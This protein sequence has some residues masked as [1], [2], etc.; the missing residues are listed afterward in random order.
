MFYGDSITQQGGYALFVEQYARNH[1]PDW[2]LHFYNAGVGGDTVQGG[3]AGDISLRL[4]RDVIRLKP[5]V[6]T[7]ML[8]MNDGRYR[9]MEPATRQAF[10]DG[11]RALIAR[12]RQA[13]PE[14]RLYLIRTSPFDDYSVTPDFAPGYDLALRELGDVVTAIGQENNIPVVDFGR[15]V[16]A[17]IQRVA[18]ENR[19][20]AAQLL[21]DRVHPGPA[22]QLVMGATLL[23]AW[24]APALVSRVAIDA[25]AGTV[26]SAENTQ[27]SAFASHD[28]QLSWEQLDRALP[29]PLNYYDGDTDLAQKAGADLE[30]L[31]QQRLIL[32]GLPA[33]RYELTIDD[34][35]FGPFTAAELAAG[36]NL[37]RYNTPM[38]WQAYQV[39][40]SAEGGH[41]RQRI[42]RRAPAVAADAL[43]AVEEA[44]QVLRSN[45]ARPQ[46]R[47]FSV[48]R[49]P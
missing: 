34:R 22:A 9:P 10:S 32:S 27:V 6:V 20:L 28:G 48:R 7:I 29:L 4:E 16:S 2:T 45:A 30:S 18:A 41:E 26:L 1:Y 46:V 38:R 25:T 5:T 47:K 24:Q 42:A 43:N 39:R 49:I 14:A 3:G 17:G 44:E 15:S 33:G 13:L 35:K 23:R 8:G 31:D 11:Y 21:P 40:W 19:D 37:A 36:I 12:L